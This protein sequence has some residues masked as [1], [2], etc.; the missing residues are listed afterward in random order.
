MSP[1]RLL[2]EISQDV[3][4]AI[5]G[6]RQNLG[7]AVIVTLILALGIGANT[8]V[9]SLINGLILR[10]LPVEKPEEL[11]RLSNPGFSYPIVE[12]V[13]KRA[14]DI[15]S[16]LFA[17][18]IEDLVVDW[19]GEVGTIQTLIVSDEFYSTLGIRPA[20]GRTFTGEDQ[21]V[22]I[23]YDSWERRFFRDPST[24]GRLIRVGRLPMTIIGV[25]PKGFFGVAPG[26]APEITIPLAS[27]SQI[28]P[29]EPDPQRQYG[30]AWLHIMARL[31]SGLS[32]AQAN[33][34]FQ[35]FWPQ[36][37]E[38]VTDPN[39]PPARRAR[40][41]SRRT[42]LEQARSGFSRVR[43]GIS[44]SLL[45]LLALVG[46]L[47][48][49][50]CATVANLLLARAEARRREM[51]VRLAIGA[52]RGRIIRQ[53][54]TE[55]LVLAVLGGLGGL[56]IA[57]WE[58]TMLMSLLSTPEDPVRLHTVMDGWVLGFSS[59]LCI[60]TAVFFA[61]APAFRSAS[62]DVG[63][64]LK[65]DTRILSGGRRWLGRLLV[66]AQVAISF[67]LVFGAA[68]FVRSLNLILSEDAGFQRENLLIVSSDAASA[69]YDEP[70]RAAFYAQLIEV[71]SQHPGIQSVSL[72]QYPPI[73]GEDGSWTGSI[74]I[75]NVP[76]QQGP[77]IVHFNA[78]SPHF[79]RTVGIQLLKGRDF[80]SQDNGSEARTIVI[81]QALARTFFGN[82]DPIGHRI[83]VGLDPLHQNM[84][85]VGVVQDA[86][87]QT[88]QE[89]PHRIAYIPLLHGRLGKPFLQVRTMSNTAV[90]AAVV[91]D[92]IRNL[93]R[94]V[95]VTIQT[96]EDRIRE[97]LV[98][99]RAVA[100]LS[101]VLGL[102]AVLLASAG[103][104]GLMAYYINRGANEI[105]LRIALGASGRTI[106][107][108]VLQKTLMLA[109][110]GALFGLGASLALARF[111]RG[112]LYGIGAADPIALIGSSLI[113]CGVAFFAGYLPAYRASRMSPAVALRV[114]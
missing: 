63:P 43:N 36:V 15:F 28:N 110:V 61:M 27:L 56:L 98:P 17:W 26:M 75:D 103:L 8:A 69:G 30:R 80:Q 40:F 62:V 85:I 38:A 31:K 5:R 7:F 48:L 96:A 19:N 58:S 111:V 34:A 42:A 39:M 109:G 89:S 29:D 52:S 105:G 59:L 82:E 6:L 114:R 35:I 99:Q 100:L 93:D 91:R 60:F 50:G 51:A 20:Y 108:M 14:G 86:K 76:P 1:L 71:L 2:D 22:V 41:L 9:F 101:T 45:I 66:V 25:A 77:E 49:V 112:A 12:Q 102:V 72:S 106:R 92:E 67:I 53:L 18:S 78:V 90:I 57:A 32:L 84:E 33:S 79:F 88:L 68:L 11:V 23:S 16:S 104:Y 24:I 97:T 70:R 4:Y 13:R 83:S 87:Y 64:V 65:D 47:L 95:A 107:M 46:L 21:A 44:Q 113:M 37:M 74:G 81:N 55:G 3:R 94:S 73:S 54:L 10:R